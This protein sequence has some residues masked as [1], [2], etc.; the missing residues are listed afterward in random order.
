[1]TKTD[2]NDRAMHLLLL[3][4]SFI[5]ARN[6]TSFVCQVLYKYILL[7]SWCNSL[8]KNIPFYAN[9]EWTHF[10]PAAMALVFIYQ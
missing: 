3:L 8:L 5:A 9:A 6:H 4:S 7:F 10:Y 2:V 1:M